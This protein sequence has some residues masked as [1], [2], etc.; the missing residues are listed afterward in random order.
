MLVFAYDGALL[1]FSIALLLERIS[2]GWQNFGL[3]YF[4]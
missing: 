1:G 3:S 2:H 4:W